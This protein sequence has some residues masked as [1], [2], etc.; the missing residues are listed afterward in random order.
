MSE[1]ELHDVAAA[2]WVGLRHQPDACEALLW[3]YEEAGGHAEGAPWYYASIL[4]HAACLRQ[5]VTLSRRPH[6]RQK[7]TQCVYTITEIG[8]AAAAF[9]ARNGGP[10]D[11]IK[12]SGIYF[13]QGE[14]TRLIK[15]GFA[16]A[17]GRRIIDLQCG[18]PDVLHLIWHY[19][20]PFS[21]EVELHHRFA[22]SRAHGEWFHPTPDLMAYIKGGTPSLLR[23]AA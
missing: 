15:I 8:K 19:E 14:V 11:R 21:H 1:S 18:S 10:P 5:C 7:Q 16:S 9:I 13:I 17:I 2:V 20:A 12:A 6:P 4:R 3:L 23:E 22:A